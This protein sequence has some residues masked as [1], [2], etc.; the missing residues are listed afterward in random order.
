MERV[1]TVAADFR[2]G[3]ECGIASEQPGY[4]TLSMALGRFLPLLVFRVHKFLI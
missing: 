1:C 4:K 2:F 3:M